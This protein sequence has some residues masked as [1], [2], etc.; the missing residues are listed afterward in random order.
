MSDTKKMLK[1]FLEP[2]KIELPHTSVEYK[3]TDAGLE[4]TLAEQGNAGISGYTGAGLATNKDRNYTYTPTRARGIGRDLGLYHQAFLESQSYQDAWGK[5]EQ[6]LVTSHW[7]VAPA[8]VDRPEVQSYLKRQAEAVQR[9]LFGI[10]GGWVKH[11]REALY[12]LIGGFAPF[13]R[14]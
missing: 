4:L 11:I 2:K 7:H 14:S 3:R 8:K 5:I 1:E 10:D 12:M 13:T 9:V 6:G